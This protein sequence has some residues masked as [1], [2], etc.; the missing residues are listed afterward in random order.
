MTGCHR[1]DFSLSDNEY[2][3]F[4]HISPPWQ[5]IFIGPLQPIRSAFC[6]FERPIHPQ[7]NTSPIIYAADTTIAQT[8][9]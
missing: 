4:L 5:K 1:L 3:H 9:C 8:A 6:A 7:I 2:R